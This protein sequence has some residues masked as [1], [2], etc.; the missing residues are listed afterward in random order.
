M[1]GRVVFLDTSFIVALE[2]RDDPAHARAKLLDRGV[3]RLSPE[4]NLRQ[5]GRP[6]NLNN[7]S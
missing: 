7:G 5:Q 2:N 3:R 1:P 6:K 4:P